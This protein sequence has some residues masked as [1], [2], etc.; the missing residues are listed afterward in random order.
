MC[1]CQA[2]RRYPSALRPLLLLSDQTLLRDQT[3]LRDQTRQGGAPST[4]GAGSAGEDLSVPVH[5]RERVFAR[6]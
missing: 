4:N 5:V 2:V 1:V 6:I 3:Q